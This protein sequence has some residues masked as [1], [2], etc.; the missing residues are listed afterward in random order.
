VFDAGD[1][2]QARST[3]GNTAVAPALPPHLQ[4]G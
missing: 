2:E 4:R 1:I 3:V